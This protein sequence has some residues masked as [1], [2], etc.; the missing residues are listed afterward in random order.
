MSINLL[1]FILCARNSKK[2]YYLQMKKFP[3][4][5]SFALLLLLSACKGSKTASSTP[6][7]K[8]AVVF[9]KS[10]TLTEVLDKAAKEN[11]LVF[12]DFYATWC[13]PCRVMDEDVYTD[14]SVANLMN[15]NF[16]NYKVDGEE[17]NGLN[18]T[19]IFQ[20]EYYPTI[21]F[22]DARGRL[23]EKKEGS[24]AQTELKEMANRVLNAST[25]MTMID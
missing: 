16:V 5:L 24:V 13:L 18:L 23:I 2:E 7:K 1:V 10:E 11:K 9:E 8:D 20:V 17:G 12:V 22:L 15:D 19:T 3:Y 6:I 25:G 4:I 21:L 14:K